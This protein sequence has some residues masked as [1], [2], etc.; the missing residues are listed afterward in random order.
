MG[1]D[2]GGGGG[3]SKLLRATMSWWLQAEGITQRDI[4]MTVQ[5][6]FLTAW[7]QFQEVGRSVDLMPELLAGMALDSGPCLAF[8]ARLA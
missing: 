1:V 2:G 8:P 6:T 7:D 4:D 5:A 3:E